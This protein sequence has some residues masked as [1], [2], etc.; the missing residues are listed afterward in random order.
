MANTRKHC[1]GNV[2]L[3]KV[4]MSFEEWLAGLLE[5]TEEK[6][7]RECAECGE[8][9]ECLRANRTFAGIR[10]EWR[11]ERGHTF[12]QEVSY[13]HLQQMYSKAKPTRFVHEIIYP[14]KLKNPGR[15]REG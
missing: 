2:H 1:Q 4:R 11:C 14:S 3:H 12:A 8:D 15:R 10:L 7:R 13:A 9:C 5:Y 6:G